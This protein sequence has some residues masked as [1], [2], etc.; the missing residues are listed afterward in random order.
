M[1][2]VA[3]LFLSEL[4]LQS[5][6][7]LRHTQYNLGDNSIIDCVQTNESAVCYLN[8]VLQRRGEQLDAI[9]LFS[10]RLVKK[11]I[12]FRS[13]QGNEE[14]YDTQELFFVQRVTGLYRNLK[15]KIITVDYDD[16]AGD[17]SAVAG[18]AQESILQ[19]LKMSEKVK[20]YAAM[21]ATD[22]IVLHADM[23]GGFRHASMMMLSV[24]QMLKFSGIEIGRVVYSDFNKKKI[25]D[26]T[27][28]Q[29]MFTL[30]SGAD[31][32]V[33]YGSVAAI[34]DYFKNIIDDQSEEFKKLF[35]AMKAFSDAI[36]ICQ[37][38]TI[39]AVLKTLGK[40][41]QDFQQHEPKTMHEELFS[42]IVDTIHAGYRGM[43]EPDASRLDIIDWC[44]SKGFLQQAMT[45]CTEWLPIM[46]VDEQICYPV[47]PNVPEQMSKDKNHHSWQQNFIITYNKSHFL[48]AEKATLRK[49]ILDLFRQ[50][51]E[52]HKASRVDLDE[53]GIKSGK[54]WE[55]LCVFQQFDSSVRKARNAL[56]KAFSS[57]APLR[58]LHGLFSADPI[59]AMF[60][61][62]LYY[63]VPLESLIGF[64]EFIL[65]KASQEYAMKTLNGTSANDMY[66][67]F[68]I[69]DDQKGH[70]SKKIISMESRS[71]GKWTVRKAQL[72]EMFDSTIIATR[73]KEEYPLAVLACYDEIRLQRNAMNHVSEDGV[74]PPEI[75]RGKIISCIDLLRN[76]EKYRKQ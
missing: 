35:E 1:K 63:R 34:E 4:H 32:F 60:L 31:E 52:G 27:E 11:P 13:D 14:Y 70:K 67:L 74:Q 47:S 22:H 21:N 48:V 25:I 28:I 10:T 71:A 57:D 16:G 20:E 62:F 72:K 30:V 51:S 40:R 8:H 26:V 76:K 9:F 18:D 65:K 56:K 2:H 49:N 23:T 39:E 17:S 64:D 46:I 5:D 75:I 68:K 3:L 69:D 45:M 24:I 33:N 53:L 12:T 59:F 43:I 36:K 38:D 19:V 55:F 37:I 44:I 58:S 41:I 50:I 42:Q 73:Y 54:L 29:R 15:N 61:K 7:S 6:G 66:A